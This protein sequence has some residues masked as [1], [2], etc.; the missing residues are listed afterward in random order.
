MRV[1][2]TGTEQLSKVA[3]VLA[4]QGNSK[5]L[6]RRMAKS[7]KKASDPITRDQRQNLA[8]RLPHSGGAAATISGE[9]RLTAR[10]SSATPSVTISASWPGHDMGAIERGSLR[11]PTFGRSEDEWHTTSVEPGLLSGPFND[12]KPTVVAELAKE[13]DTLAEEIARS[14]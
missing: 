14:T 4:A 3:D 5:A 7:F 2:V 1:K 13:M 8:E 9:A 12:H 6:K 11:H 10:T